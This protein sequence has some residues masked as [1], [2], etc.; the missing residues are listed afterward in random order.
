MSMNS[1]LNQPS[2]IGLHRSN[3]LNNISGVSPNTKNK[4]SEIILLY[5]I[6]ENSDNESSQPSKQTTFYIHKNNNNLNL[7]KNQF[8]LPSGIEL[9]KIVHNK[10]N[11]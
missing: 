11:H 8:K 9:D 3:Y 5:Y 7:D 1:E 6:E 4:R 10:R 2:T